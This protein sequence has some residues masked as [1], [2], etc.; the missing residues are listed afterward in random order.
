MLSLQNLRKYFLSELNSN[1]ANE[2]IKSTDP[3][4]DYIEFFKH[5]PVRTTNI[6][7]LSFRS[8]RQ[9]ITLISQKNKKQNL[10]NKS[11]N[12]IYL[13][14]CYMILTFTDSEKLKELIN[15]L[16]TLENK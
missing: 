1:E 13:T 15:A 8:K 10:Q 2:I 12:I 9:I 14:I 16:E 6:T 7:N 4:V 5:I 3:L 11:M